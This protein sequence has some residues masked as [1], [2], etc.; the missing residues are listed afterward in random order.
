MGLGGIVSPWQRG[1]QLYTLVI[2]STEVRAGRGVAEEEGYNEERENVVH[3][4][5]GSGK[6]GRSFA[7]ELEQ[8]S[9]ERVL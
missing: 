7:I 8:E 2:G 9:R 6:R 1:L 5:I 4:G 3:C